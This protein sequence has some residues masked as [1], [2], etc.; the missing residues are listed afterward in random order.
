MS[1]A[2]IVYG[3]HTADRAQ[4]SHP[5]K[6]RNMNKI[7][8]PAIS[9]EEAE[10]ACVEVGVR[11]V[12]GRIKLSDDETVDA[13]SIV[14]DNQV[15]IALHAVNTVAGLDSL[16]KR[17]FPLNLRGEPVVPR[18][19]STE[20]DADIYL[21]GSCDPTTWRRDVCIPMCE[22][23]G[24]TYYNPQVDDWKPEL[25]AIEAKAKEEASLLFFVID[26][27]T[28]AIGSMLEAAEYIGRGRRVV[29][30]IQEMDQAGGPVKVGKDVLPPAEVKDLTR[31]RRFLKDVA[32]RAGVPCFSGAD[33]IVEAM[34][35]AIARCNGRVEMT[36]NTEHD[37]TIERM[38]QLGET[39]LKE[40]EVDVFAE[41]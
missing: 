5:A 11:A 19:Y 34:Q 7:S 29:L 38:Q 10:L 6:T 20:V 25:V 27:A 12:W 24:V 14:N 15:V 16:C 41:I 32:S 1:D 9:P 36:V 33:A 18:N 17:V 30:V 26:N 28:R 3:T 31:A 37:A 8:K 2:D 4:S 21:G 22:L 39:L 40:A 23:H 13:P 35:A